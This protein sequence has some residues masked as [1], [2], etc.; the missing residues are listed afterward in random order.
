LIL[1]WVP[2]LVKRANWKDIGLRAL[3][4][5]PLFLP[6]V[7]QRRLS[8]GQGQF[9]MEGNKPPF[10]A[11]YVRENLQHAYDFFTAKEPQYGTIP[12][13]F[14][15]GAA[16][17]VGALVWIARHRKKGSLRLWASAGTA[18]GV[19]FTH[20][21]I[22]FTYYWGNLTLQYALRLGIIFFP[23]LVV[24][25]LIAL[26]NATRDIQAARYPIV[27][28][29]VAL[30][31]FYWPIAGANAAVRQIYI[32]REFRL[33]RRFIDKTYPDKDVLVISDLS[34]LYVPFRYSAV[35]VS[36]AKGAPEFILRKGDKKLKQEI[37]VV[38]RVRYADDK[39]QEQTDLGD[40]FE[41]ETLYE[42]MYNA[43]MKLRVS[44]VTPAEGVDL[45]DAPRRPAGLLP[46]RMRG[47]R[48]AEQ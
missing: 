40:K 4:I 19:V 35:R 47:L 32:F 24:L 38:Q 21:A 3:L 2:F 16:G 29:V 23:F 20:A 5:P 46:G 22:L 30:F 44:R 9:Q 18:F 31:A 33:V 41:T 13:Y 25:V 37:V 34:N 10:A 28:G 36:R 1:P 42:T 14:W 17:L 12:L 15:L 48:D 7:W 43:G 8:F 26:Y 27:I 39:P 11:A 45:K 6:V